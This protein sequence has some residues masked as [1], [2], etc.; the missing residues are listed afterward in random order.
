MM[1]KKCIGRTSIFLD[2]CLEPSDHLDLK[3]TRIESFEHY[4]W[5]Y[6][7]FEH[8]TL[9]HTSEFSEMYH[10]IFHDYF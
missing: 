6:Y 1:E 3:W 4:A 7:Y 5:N 10:W 2:F 8:Y 9:L